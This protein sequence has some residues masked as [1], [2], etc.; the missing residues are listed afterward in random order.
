VFLVNITWLTLG[1]LHHLYVWRVRKGI[2]D[3]PT[4]I[5]LIC[6]AGMHKEGRQCLELIEMT[7][8]AL[9]S[10]TVALILL[11]VQKCNLEL[12]IKKAIEQ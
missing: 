8:N 5:T 3:Q 12:N 10:G 4:C 11:S 6:C 9:Y 2:V 7:A 1:E